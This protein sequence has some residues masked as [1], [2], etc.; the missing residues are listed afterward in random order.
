M[1][2]NTSTCSVYTKMQHMPFKNTRKCKYFKLGSLFQ[3]VK[4]DKRKMVSSHKLSV[5]PA[6]ILLNNSRAN[7]FSA[8][9]LGPDYAVYFG[10]DLLAKSHWFDEVCRPDLCQNLL[11]VNTALKSRFYICFVASESRPLLNPDAKCKE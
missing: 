7:N 1:F 11:R 8:I 4:R 5:G 6:Y 9:I 2:L 3:D 10:S